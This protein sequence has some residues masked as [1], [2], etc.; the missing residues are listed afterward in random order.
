M[1]NSTRPCAVALGAFDGIH[2]GHRALIA[3][4]QRVAALRG[5]ETAVYTFANHPLSV[6][7]PQG[8]PPLLLEAGERETLFK[9]LGVNQVIQVPFDRNLAAQ[10]PE[11]FMETLA[12]ALRLGHVTV[13]YNFHFGCQGRGDGALLTELGRR[14][15]FTV[16]IVPRVDWRGEPVSATAIR[17][18]LA[19]GDV[20]RA[21][22][23]LGRDYR[24][25][26]IIVRG[27]RIGHELGFPTANLLPPP[28]RALPADGVYVASVQ[29]AGRWYGAVTNV[30]TNPTVSERGHRTVE[31]HLLDFQGD[32]YGLNCQVAFR[33]RIRGEKRF[34]SRE[35]LMEQ[36]ARDTQRARDFFTKN[37]LHP[38]DSVLK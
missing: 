32:L 35:D 13:G 8:A 34:S 15:G 25:G 7:R 28:G 11:T 16:S 38:E 1:T 27:R 9:G 3:E 19:Q 5:Y 26:G 21:N 4:N 17:S 36:I 31:S 2:L 30:G 37:H 22:A 33:D 18:L 6:L 24:I 14:M 29:V 20:A 23:M 12:R 10:S